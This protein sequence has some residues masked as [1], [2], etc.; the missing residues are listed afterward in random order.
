MKGFKTGIVKLPGLQT[1]APMQHN[2]FF[3]NDGLVRTL[4]GYIYSLV[5]EGILEEEESEVIKQ[6]AEYGGGITYK[7]TRDSRKY[8]TIAVEDVDPVTNLFAA[9]H[10]ATHLLIHGSYPEI[11]LGD[12]LTHGFNLN[13][14][15]KYNSEENIAH[16]GGFLGL[17]KQGAL[18][19][20]S[21]P[22]FMIHHELEQL[23]PLL[24]DLLQ[25]QN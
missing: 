18:K 23:Q 9:S 24:D 20:L 7:F 25:S 2:C 14:F 13:P 22:R 10:E 1:E 3:R 5:S 11:L 16:I 8:F 12:L 17:Y 21:D 15:E 6:K 19:Y 4:V